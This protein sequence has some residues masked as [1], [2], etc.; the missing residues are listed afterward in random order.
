MAWKFDR[1]LVTLSTDEENER[2]KV[3]WESESLGGMTEDNSR[4][5]VPVVYL[6]VLTVITAFLMTF[7][8]WGQRP[9]AAIYAEY[10]NLMNT[11]EIMAI[12]DDTVA[13]AKIVQMSKGIQQATPTGPSKWNYDALRDRHP[14][15][16]DDMRM[17]KPEIEALMAKGV[18]LEDYT[19]V[20]DQVVFANFEWNY[21]ADGSQ[22][23]KQPWWDKGYTIDVFYLSM[24]FIGVTIVVKCL[25]HYSWQPR[26]DHDHSYE[27]DHKL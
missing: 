27:S 17:I 3:L 13:M 7:P 5:P 19:V 26:H 11:P 21:R 14:V 22:E 4:T 25:P 12:A 9:N 24:F 18:D 1:P 2:A 10:V 20:G 15:T 6:V 16:M 8:L 23:R